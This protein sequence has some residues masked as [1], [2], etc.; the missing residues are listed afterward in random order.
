MTNYI[1]K[2]NLDLNS[3]KFGFKIGAGPVDLAD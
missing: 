1:F 2:D 3:D